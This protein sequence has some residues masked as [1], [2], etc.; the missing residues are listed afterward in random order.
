MVLG[1]KS[2]DERSCD[3]GMCLISNKYLSETVVVFR[4][5]LDF[6]LAADYNFR[7]LV[8]WIRLFVMDRFDETA[9][10]R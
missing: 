4:A 9:E 2:R 8:A 5:T 3:L 1:W 6:G 10:L 7:I